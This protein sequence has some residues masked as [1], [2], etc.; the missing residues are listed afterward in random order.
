MDAIESDKAYRRRPPPLWFLRDGLVTVG[1]VSTNLLVRGVIEERVPSDCL[2]R[3]RAWKAWRH[4]DR[5]REIATL[6][7]AQAKYGV[8]N[9]ERANWTTVRARQ[10]TLDRFESDL[11]RARD[12]GDVLSCTLTEAM[13]LT[14]ASVGAVH[15][16]RPPYVGLVTS[17]AAGPGMHRRLG[18]VVS[19]DD[20]IL[21]HA[22]RGGTIC[23]RP[24]YGMDSGIVSVRLGALPACSAVAMVPV[25]CFGRLY[26]M[27]ELGRSDH[28]FRENDFQNVVS[29]ASLAAERLGLV[30]NWAQV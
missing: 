23:E 15:R 28:G 18:N 24:R 11:R 25:V 16:R 4:L 17:Y 2:V 9:V 8:V 27:L 26:A 3:E 10:A 1:P 20:P 7:R 21:S 19:E 30:R 13:N 14:S 29:I 6:R 5:I 12:P 22:R